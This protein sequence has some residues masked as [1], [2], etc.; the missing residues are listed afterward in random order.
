MWAL[1]SH[2]GNFTL[3]HLWVEQ[4]VTV[5]IHSFQVAAHTR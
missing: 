2:S 4:S 3:Q 5:F 1:S